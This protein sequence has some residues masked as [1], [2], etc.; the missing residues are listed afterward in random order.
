MRTL[1]ALLFAGVTAFATAAGAA[2]RRVAVLEPDDELVR[3]ITLSLSPWDVET[4]RSDATPPELSQPNAV[5]IATRLARWLQVEAVIWI[6]RSERA[7]LLWVFDA[8]T[9]DVTAR[10]LAGA[11]PFDGAA[12]AAVAL[13]VKTALRTSSVAPPAERFGAEP[14]PSSAHHPL[15]FEL[16]GAGHWISERALEVRFELGAVAWL[17]LERR[18][19]V[20]LELSAGPG[21]SLLDERFRG[22]YREYGASADLRVRLIREPPFAGD[23]SFGGGL[24]WTRLEGTLAANSLYRDVARRSAALDAEALV[25]VDM[26]G[27]AYLGVSAGVRYLPSYRRYLVEG[28]PVFSPWL[29]SPSLAGHIGVGLF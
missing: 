25:S 29:L 23:V 10:M 16:G 18:V 5:E 28:T 21:V 22:R 1:T 27:G 24:Y 3:A 6:S 8:A 12:A 9:G 11:P 14:P 17:L 7:T 2:P 26:G 15:A 20:G 13:S 4:T 19:G